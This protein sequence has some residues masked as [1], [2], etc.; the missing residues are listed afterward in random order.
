MQSLQVKTPD[1]VIMAN[2]DEY[3]LL[4]GVFGMLTFFSTLHILLYIFHFIWTVF[5]YQIQHPELNRIKGDLLTCIDL[6]KRL[7][8]S[9]WDLILSLLINLL[10]S[11]VRWVQF[12]TE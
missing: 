1:A 4:L 11:W 8:Y 5:Q 9:K 6:V 2:T 10:A 7:N 3:D 12:N